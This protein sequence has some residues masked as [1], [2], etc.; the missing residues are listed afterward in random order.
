MRSIVLRP[1]EGELVQLGQSCAVIKASVETTEGR[2]ALLETTFEPHFPGPMAHLHRAT[3]DM[4]SC[5]RGC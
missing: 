4:S 5:L 1:S 3:I 2:F